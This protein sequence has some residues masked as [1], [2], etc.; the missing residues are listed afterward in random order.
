[1]RNPYISCFLKWT[2]YCKILGEKPTIKRFIWVEE[3][4]PFLKKLRGF[5]K[6][7]FFLCHKAKDYEFSLKAILTTLHEHLKLYDLGLEE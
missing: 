7:H 4:P 1:L 2:L 3:L 5:N 6:W